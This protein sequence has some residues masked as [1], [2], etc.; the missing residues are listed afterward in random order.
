MDGTLLYHENEHDIPHI[1]E[2]T[3][4]VLREVQA[5]G[6][7]IFI[8]TGR[9]YAFLDKDVIDFGFDGYVLANGAAVIYHDQV[10]VHHPLDHERVEDMV[11]K[12]E[13]R[14]IEYTMQT[15]D[16]SYLKK[17]FKILDMFYHRCGVNFDYIQ[18]EFSPKDHFHDTIKLEMM[19]MSEENIEYCRSLEDD[20]FD[21][22]GEPPFNMEFYARERSKATGILEVLKTLDIPIEDSYAFGDGKNDIEMLETVGHGIAMGNASEEVKK[23]AKEVCLSCFENGVAKKLTELFL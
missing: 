9:P 16:Y 18:Y 7:L 21:R 14:Q 4:K 10:L 8:A 11:N 12:L 2:E 1:H 3:K 19:P 22:M 20:Y 5:K 17:D 6:H 15:I 13:E 23:H